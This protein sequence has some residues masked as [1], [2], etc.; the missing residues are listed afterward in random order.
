MRLD[1][2]TPL[3]KMLP[4]FLQNVSTGHRFRKALPATSEPLPVLL[5]IPFPGRKHGYYFSS[6]GLCSNIIS[7]AVAFLTSLLEIVSLSLSHPTPLW[8]SQSPFAGCF[9]PTALITI[10]HIAYVLL[11]LLFTAC[12]PQYSINPR[13]QEFL[14][15]LFTAASSVP[16]RMFSTGWIFT[17]KYLAVPLTNAFNYLWDANNFVAVFLLSKVFPQST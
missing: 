15:I 10:W 5:V 6:L 1:Y 3:L 9:I 7:S 2:A 8:Y 11:I 13:E 14:S 16:R 4:C 12:L 17:Y